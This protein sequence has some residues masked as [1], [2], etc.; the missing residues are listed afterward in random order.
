MACVLGEMDLVWAVGYA[1][2]WYLSE[3]CVA[4][5]AGWPMGVQDLAGLVVRDLLMPVVWCATF[6]R[7]GFEWRG[8]KME[9]TAQ[10]TTGA[11]APSATPSI[12]PA[13]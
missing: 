11:A 10:K 1:G 13:E 6:L 7:R 2:L 5:R 4:K 8:T 12:M 9:P 3:I